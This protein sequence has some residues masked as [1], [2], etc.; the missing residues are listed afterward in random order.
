MRTVRCA[1]AMLALLAIGLTAP[2]LAQGPSGQQK[3]AEIGSA[4]GDGTPHGADPP[5]APGA[6]ARPTAGGP[7]GASRETMPSKYSDD[8]ARADQIPIMAKP[9]PLTDE[10]KRR[11]LDA[12]AGSAAPAAAV[13]AKPAQE[14]SSTVE[15]RDLPAGLDDQIPALRTYKYVALRDRVLLVAPANRIVVQE[16]AR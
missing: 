6:D 8:I 7:I 15:L 9:L 1:T 14:L 12:A 2:G 10:Q 5:P 4:P 16:I 3:P 13:N 11:I